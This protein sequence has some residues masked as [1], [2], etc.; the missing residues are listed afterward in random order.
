MALYCARHR[1]LFNPANNAA[2]WAL[3]QGT[4]REHFWRSVWQVAGAFTGAG[5]ALWVLP[6]DWTK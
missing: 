3:G 2:A 5:L 6:A 1:A 4:A